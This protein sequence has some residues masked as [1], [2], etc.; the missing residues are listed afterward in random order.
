MTEVNPLNSSESS[1]PT[2]PSDDSSSPYYLHP[3]DNP[4]SL[5][6][7]EIFVGDNYITWSRS[8]TM[9][10]TIKNKVA[11]INGSITAPPTNQHVHHTA[12]LRA[13][14][15]V[16]S[17]LMNSISKDIRNSLL[18]VASAVDL[19]NELKTRYLRSDGPRVFLLEKS[20]SS[21]TQGSSS[22]TEYFSVFKTLWDE[23]QS[24]YVLKFLVGLND[25]YASVRSQ[26]LLIFPLPSMAKVFSLLLQEESQRQLTNSVCHETHALLVKQNTQPFVQSK[27]SKDKQKKSS[28]YCT[29][30]GYNGHTM[31]NCFQV[32]GYPPGWIG[33]KGKRNLPT[34]HA[35]ISTG[36]VYIQN[37]NEN[38][39]FSLTFEEFTKLLALANSNPSPTPAVNL[40]TSQFS[41]PISK[42]DDW[43]CI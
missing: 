10:L 14:N 40:V 25:S 36:E 5:L 42:E 11:F 32:H 21:I 12:W 35:A 38:Q 28:L 39:K 19:W 9:A 24:E 26:L 8:I 29:H 20:L 23:Y 33:L 41:G 1:R 6:D 27:F 13:N 2:N 22:I 30:C 3:S 31:E 17:W 37:S 7:S 4:G 34:A 43:D 18:Y 16:L 15:L